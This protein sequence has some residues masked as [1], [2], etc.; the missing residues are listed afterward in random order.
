MSSDRE[1]VKPASF[2]TAHKLSRNCSGDL[3]ADMQLERVSKDLQTCKSR[4]LEAMTT[5]ALRRINWPK[6][7]VKF[8]VNGG[9]VSR[10]FLGC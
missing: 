10:K 5:V 1:G 2:A 6:G 8:V 3:I 7:R 4:A 9:N